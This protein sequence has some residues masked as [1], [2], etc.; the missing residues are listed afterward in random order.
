MHGS[1][2]SVIEFSDV[3]F[4]EIE[5]IE[6]QRSGQNDLDQP[7]SRQESEIVSPNYTNAH[8][9]LSGKQEKGN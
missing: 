1:N 2:N 9:E 7:I 4:S 6:S 5:I 8:N 3:T